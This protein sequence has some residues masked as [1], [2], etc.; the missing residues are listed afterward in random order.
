MTTEEQ[1]GLLNVVADD[2]GFP[3]D[4]EYVLPSNAAKILADVV[5]Y[6]VDN[7]CPPMLLASLVELAE[8]LVVDL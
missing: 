3:T 4:A 7:D 2:L 1:A 5:R 6:P 8:I